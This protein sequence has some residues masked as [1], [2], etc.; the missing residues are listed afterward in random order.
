MV[1]HIARNSLV[2]EDVDCGIRD[3]D[4]VEFIEDMLIDLVFM[5]EYELADEKR[6]ED[7]LRLIGSFEAAYIRRKPQTL[8]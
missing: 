3:E 1:R 7:M 6:K 4:I 8:C 5:A 2:V